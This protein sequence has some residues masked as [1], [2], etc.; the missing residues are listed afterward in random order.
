MIHKTAQ[1]KLGGLFFAAMAPAQ[2]ILG[3]AARQTINQKFSKT[4]SRIVFAYQGPLPV[5][6]LTPIVFMI[7][8]IFSKDGLRYNRR[9]RGFDDTVALP[10]LKLSGI[11]VFLY[12]ID[13]PEADV[14]L[15]LKDEA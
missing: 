7:A 11:F 4:K 2:A 3:V 9:P 15:V 6:V 10:G 14:G 5:R 13:F 12:L 1:L 8:A